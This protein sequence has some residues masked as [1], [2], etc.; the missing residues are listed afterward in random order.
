MENV[1]KKGIKSS[2]E[3]YFGGKIKDRRKRKEKMEKTEEKKNE[4]TYAKKKKTN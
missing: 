1:S 4:R 3:R 2:K